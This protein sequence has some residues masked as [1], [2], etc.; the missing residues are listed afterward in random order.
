MLSPGKSKFTVEEIYNAAKAN[1]SKQQALLEKCDDINVKNWYGS[2]LHLA[3][4]EG[5]FQAVRSLIEK[6]GADVNDFNG[7]GTT[8]LHMASC[9]EYVIYWSLHW[10]ESP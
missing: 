10:G 3:A 8:P 2:A 5:H 4:H 9:I 6:G 1:D 7:H